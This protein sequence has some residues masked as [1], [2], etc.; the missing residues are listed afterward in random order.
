[1]R[2]THT[3]LAATLAA[4]TL[5]MV[6]QAFAPST[7]VATFK[8]TLQ[9]TRQAGLAR[10]AAAGHTRM[11]AE[12]KPRVVVIGAGWGGWAA[13]KA[14]CENGCAVTLLD[15]VPDP[16]G[17]RPM[18]TPTGKPFEV[19]QRGFWND[20]PNVEALLAEKNVPIDEVLTDFTGAAFWGAN[21][22]EAT[23]PVM[24]APEYGQYLQLPSPLGQA[25]A[26]FPGMARLPI[27][28]AVTMAGLLYAILDFDRDEATFEKYDRMTAHDLFIRMGLS[29]RLIDDFIRPTLLVGIFKPPEEVSAAVALELLYFFVLAH[30]TSFDVRWVKKKSIQETMIN[31]L[32]TSLIEEHNLTLLPSS[33]VT[34]V[35]LDEAGERVAGV[36]YMDG[37]GQ[38]KHL[39]DLD[40][41]V[42]ALGSKGMKSVVGG[43]PALARK[44]EE[45]SKAAALQAIDVVS[46]RLWLD[47]TVRT[48][49]PANVFS[50]FEELRGAGGSFF[51]LDQ[52]Q[53]DHASLWGGAEVQG[54]VLACDFY[55][56]GAIATLSDE[57]IVAL[58]ME[59]LLPKAS[60]DFAKAKVVDSY[61]G[62]YRDAVS[63]FSPGSFRSRPPIQ[64]SIKN[65]VCAGDWVR[66]GEREHGAK[67]LCQ[68][69]AYVS[70]LEAAN[71]LA[72][73]GVLG[74]NKKEH[75]VLAIRADQPQVVAA[76]AANKNLMLLL[77]P[78]GLDSP[79]VR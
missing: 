12:T 79:W 3:L 22:L 15:G 34:Q 66:M 37:F 6:V 49:R 25:L 56:A 71:A 11:Q 38:T 13:A 58:L 24:S 45:L 51:M 53:P 35:R 47:S 43:S 63:W 59:T 77:K 19:G 2:A 74:A 17:T 1:M 18:L 4:T 26:A 50:R 8:G 20:Y 7:I 16:S 46:V 9:R 68:E 30:Q 54:S 21:G 64:T 44:C 27:T 61:V 5:A 70:G 32:A 62:R 23:A 36:S 72:R 57:D 76:R 33:R 69:R 39:E 48:T 31:P 65:L 60:P 41:C 14:L 73:S 28:D 29:K 78:W 67:G 75:Q 10:S 52:L 40:A 55:N 42:L